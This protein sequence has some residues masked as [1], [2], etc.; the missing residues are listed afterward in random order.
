MSNK[1]K[2]LKQSKQMSLLNFLRIKNFFFLRFL[3]L[4][5]SLSFSLFNLYQFKF[6]NILFTVLKLKHK[7][8][9]KNRGNFEKDL[10]KKKIYEYRTINQAE[11]SFFFLFDDLKIGNTVKKLQKKKLT[12]NIVNDLRFQVNYNQRFC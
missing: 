5:L 6:F 1:W 10:I 2:L 4:F 3:S 8:Q 12:R 11:N 9:K 7:N